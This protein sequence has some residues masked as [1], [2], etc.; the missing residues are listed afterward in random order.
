MSFQE[1]L[2]PVHNAAGRLRSG[3]D[4]PNVSYDR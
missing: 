1:A 4:G 3:G 2:S